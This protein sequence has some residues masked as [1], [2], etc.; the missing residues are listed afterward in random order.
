RAVERVAARAPGGRARRLLRFR[1]DRGGPVA[2]AAPRR[3]RRQA[4]SRLVERVGTAR[5]TGRARLESYAVDVAV[6]PPKWARYGCQPF[7]ILGAASRMNRTGAGAFGGWTSSMRAS[8]NV[9]LP[10]WWL[11]GAHA[12]TTF[13]QIDSPPRDLGITWSR[14]SRPAV[15]PQYTQRQPSRAKSARREIF[16]CT[17]RGTR[18]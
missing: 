10:L 18:T 3:P 15:V 1:R 14:V 7:G 16:R 12:V 8:S 2:P 4:L 9:R 13:S 11:H 6:P 5:P 17:A